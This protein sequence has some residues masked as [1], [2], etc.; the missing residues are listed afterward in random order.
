MKVFINSQRPFVTTGCLHTKTSGTG[1][2]LRQRWSGPQTFT[3]H[4]SQPAAQQRYLHLNTDKWPHFPILYVLN[5]ESQ[6]Q[7]SQL[8]GFLPNSKILINSLQSLCFM[9]ACF[10][11]VLIGINKHLHI[12]ALNNTG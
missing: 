3:E 12:A 4:H 10:S 9:Q 1:T 2:I 8:K 5:N 6:A 11:N 7:Q